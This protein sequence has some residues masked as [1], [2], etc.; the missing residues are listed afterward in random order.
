MAF[1]FPGWKNYAGGNCRSKYNSHKETVDGIEFASRKEAKRY[2]EL[3]L[4][5]QAGEL[6]DLELQ[7]KYV[8]IP[9]QREPDTIG[10]KGGV[11]PGKVIER[12]IAYVADFVYKDKNGI[13]HVEDI[14]GYKKTDAGAYK[15]FTIKRKLM[16]WINGITIEEV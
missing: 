6:T 11:K 14:K 15:V 5:E 10:P 16:L 13:E 1:R 3:K 7:K 4:L 2:M 8:L 12:E 9:T